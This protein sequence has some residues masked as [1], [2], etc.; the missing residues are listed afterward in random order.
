M[1]GLSLAI[2]DLRLPATAGGDLPRLP[3]L[4]R[5]LRRGRR[6]PAPPDFRHWVLARAGWRPPPRLPIASVVAGRPGHFALASPVHL[7]AGLDRVHLHPAG[8]LRLEPGELDEIATSFNRSLGGDGVVLEPHSA[9]LAL[10]ALP[11]ALECETHDPAPLSGRDAGA[12]LP[13]GPDGGWLRRLMTEAQMLLHE[14]PVNAARAA[15]GELPANGLWLWG[16]GGDALPAPP[17]SLPPLATSDAFLSALWRRHGAELAPTAAA[18]P[19]EF[20]SSRAGGGIAALGLF[21]TPVP[22]SEAL[23]RAEALVFSPLERAL[24]GGRL[25]ELALWIAGSAFVCRPRDRWRFWRRS[26]AW[27]EALA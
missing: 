13:S 2:T 9:S 26:S 14:H 12:W 11:R 22:V 8:P 4:E 19:A 6:E 17:S 24:A 20:A 27:Y 16:S 1:P 10:L 18:A 25:H 15:R 21:E 7:V 23:A 3:A 5:L